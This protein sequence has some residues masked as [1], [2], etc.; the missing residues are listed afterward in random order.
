M[1]FTISG[2]KLALHLG[3]ASKT[4]VSSPYFSLHGK[5]TT[6]RLTKVANNK[7]ANFVPWGIPPLGDAVDDNDFP[8]LTL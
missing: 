5:V 2:S 6:S 7:G 4:V 3:F 1:S 8:T